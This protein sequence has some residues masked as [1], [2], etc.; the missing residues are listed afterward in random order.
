MNSAVLVL[1]SINTD[2]VIRS[3]RLPAPGETVLGG[4]FYQAGGGKG[5][6][7]AVAAARAGRG[8]VTFVAAVGDD[9]FGSAAHARL[10]SE[11]LVCDFVKVVPGVATGVA[12]IMV[13]ERGEN[14][15]SVAPGANA[16]LSEADIRS[17]P[18]S[19]FREAAVLLASLEVPLP[20][21]LYALERA[22]QAGIRTI[23]NP[24]PAHD[25]LHEVLGRGLVDV[26]TPN[27]AE[28]VAL[29]GNSINSDQT[30]REAAQHLIAA[31]AGAVVLTRAAAGCVVAEERT[32]ALPAYTVPAVDATA[33]GDAFSGALAARLAEGE[34]LLNAARWASAAA[35]LSVT[36]AGAQPS[37]AT[38]TEIDG[39]LAN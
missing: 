35:A 19:L 7:Q 10:A 18:E 13:D 31:G 3:P 25:G 6:N 12:L 24:A 34:S 1:G 26:L 27:Q 37:L 14:A 30:S 17:L 39:F 11:C 9:D 32:I 28:A 29:S 22:K 16:R 8:P 33:A 4:E 21:V 38:R 36:R 23:L 2:L 5:A 20:T 15:I